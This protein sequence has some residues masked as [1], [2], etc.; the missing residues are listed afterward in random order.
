MFDP[1]PPRPRIS[2]SGYTSLF[3]VAGGIIIALTG[4]VMGILG[5]VFLVLLALAVQAKSRLER[6]NP[7]FA[8]APGGV[9]W[10]HPVA[11]RGA[12]AWNQIGALVVRDHRDKRQLA[13]LIVPKS[14]GEQTGTAI[15]A[16]ELPGRAGDEE[17][18]LLDLVRRLLPLLHD[19]VVLDKRTRAWLAERGLD[20]NGRFG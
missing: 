13:L 6:T 3:L 14:D 9:T 19:D 17:D 7:H 10:D 16:G 12:L 8:V 5:C 15:T 1:L 20:L 4:S 18:R 2:A 11:G